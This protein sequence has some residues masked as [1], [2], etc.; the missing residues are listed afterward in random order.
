MAVLEV[1]DD[2]PSY[3][4]P[5]DLEKTVAK[6][7]LAEI[8]ATLARANPPAAPVRASL[9]GNRTLERAKIDA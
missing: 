4:Y 8:R 3:R 9:D 5:T 6:F 1:T 2:Q 7:W